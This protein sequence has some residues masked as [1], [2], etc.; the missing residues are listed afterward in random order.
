MPRHSWRR[1]LLRGAVAAVGGL[2]VASGLYPVA[3]QLGLALARRLRGRPQPKNLGRIIAGEWALANAFQVARPLGFLGVVGP[4]RQ[5]RGPRPVVLLHGYAW[6]MANFAL[7]AR[8]LRR[9]G[10]GPLLG[11][12]YN[13]L[14]RVERAARQLGEVVDA[15]GAP[16]VDLVGHSMGGVVARAYVTLY[17]GA[18]RVTNLV[19]IG[20][21]HNGARVSK[22]GV[23]SP[24]SE[25]IVGS[26]LIRDLAAAPAPPGVRTTVIWSRA[27]GLVSSRAEAG[28]AGAEEIVFDDLGHMGMLVS[29]RVARAIAERLLRP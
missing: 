11:F 8:R 18:S 2:G 13:S 17:G 16:A 10:V 1:L 25:L 3:P 19:T 26:R 14:G 9:A 15:L 23:G 12:E 22:L 27:D 29:R 21:P 28:L 4:G 5:A 7:L 20:S 6:G 24:R